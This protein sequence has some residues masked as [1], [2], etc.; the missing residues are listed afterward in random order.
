VEEKKYSERPIIIV[1]S[2]NIFIRH[3]LVNESI[4][5]KS[6]P[7]GGVVGFLRFLDSIVYR[8]SPKKVI[9]VWENGGPSPKRK[10]LYEHYK[11]GSG[12]IGRK[13]TMKDNLRT[14][15][16]S[17]IKQLAMLFNILKK[18]PI[19]QIFIKETECDDIIGY[20]VNDYYSSVKDTMKLIVSGDKDFYQLLGDDTVKIYDPAR[21]ITIDKNWVAEKY[22]I[23]ANNFC[24]ARAF[25][26]D[27]SDNLDGIPGIGLK[28]LSKR[29]PF[30]N[31]ESCDAT[32]QDVFNGALALSNT[33]SGKRLKSMRE[34]LNNENIVKR[35][36]R[37]M[38]L[39]ISNL[40]AFQ[41]EKINGT[42]ETHEPKMNKLAF[43]KDIVG[44]GINMSFD[45]DRFSRLMIQNLIFN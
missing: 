12:K 44:N 27:P 40:A 36:W 41:I 24:L 18:T 3:Y 21:K 1:D 31:D 45:F 9:L 4:S 6:D 43:I 39:N 20:L 42:L 10:K 37:L 14:D 2:M 17:K 8:W 19:C 25:V 32:I 16:E 35:N 15:E 23:S 34:I 38:Y 5:S 29:F 7:V 26:G 28:T 13:L 22:D 30:L 11:S 33:K